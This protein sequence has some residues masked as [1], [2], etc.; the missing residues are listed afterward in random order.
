[1][2]E[3]NWAGSHT[4]RSRI[5]RVRS[6]EHLQEV[7]AAAP[8]V[9]ALGSR[10]SFTDLT[11]ITD[12]DDGVLVSLVDLP[13]RWT[14]TR[15]ARTARV[16]GRAAYGDVADRAAGGRD[17]RWATSPRS[18]TSRSRGPSRPA[19]TAPAIGNGSLAT[20]VAS[21]DIVGPDGELRT[22]AAGTPTSRA[23]SSPS[24]RSASSPRS[25]S[26]WSPPTTCARRS[27]PACP[28]TSSRPTS[29]RSPAAPTASASSPGGPAPASTRSGS[30][31][32]VDDASARDRFGAPA[33]TATLHML[34]GG[35]TE[36]VT[37]Q[38][39][40]PGPWLDRLP[41]FRM[42]FT[43]SRGEELQSEYLLPREHALDRDRAAARPRASVGAGAPGQPSCAPSPPT[44]SG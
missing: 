30:R 17:G 12:V 3:T 38:G 34:D 21:L 4:Y 31:A 6:V 42:A 7:V 39:G 37:V 16:T 20:A 27:A 40:V 15:R 9:R 14:S 18:R 24:V 28:G 29:T 23:A 1:M 13:T 25:R 19:R 26:T 33:A 5:E 32:A 43:P 2:V 36:A 11:D 41:H 8:R 35:D 10:H 44:T 22:V